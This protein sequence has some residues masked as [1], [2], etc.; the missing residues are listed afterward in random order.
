MALCDDIARVDS[1]PRDAR[2]TS[3]CLMSLQAVRK[4]VELYS[5]YSTWYE[6]HTFTH[7]KVRARPAI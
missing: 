3:T 2:G 7:G 6:G 1:K 4:F 5:L